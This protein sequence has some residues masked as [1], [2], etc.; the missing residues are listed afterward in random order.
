MTVERIPLA[1]TI[2]S[3]DGSLTKDS[4]TINCFFETRDGVKQVVKR[5]GLIA[6]AI[7]PS[8]P[9]GLARGLFA[10]SSALWA[11][12]GSNLYKIDSNFASTNYGSVDPGTPYLLSFTQCAPVVGNYTPSYSVAGTY[13]FTVPTGVTSMTFTVVGAGA[14]GGGSSGGHDAAGG[15]PSTNTA[16]G[17]GGGGAGDSV[18]STVAVTAGHVLS[19]VIG[20]G[21]TGG[22]GGY[23]SGSNG[24]N[25]GTTTVT[26]TT[27]ST[28]LFTCTGGIA[29]LGA[30]CQFSDT[31]HGLGGAGS[32]TGGSG[33]RG[34]IIDVNKFGLGG[35]SGVPNQLATKGGGTNGGSITNFV[36]GLNACGGGGGASTIGQGGIGGSGAGVAGT[37]GSGGSGAGAQSNANAGNTGGK[38]G[39]GVV[40]LTY[41]S[42]VIDGPIFLHNENTAWTIATGGGSTTVVTSSFPSGPFAFGTCY[43]DGYVFVM[44]QLGRIYNSNLEDPTTW[45]ALNYITAAFDPD[46]GVAIAKHLNYIVAFGAN[47]TQ[48][49]YDAAA[50][51]GGVGSPL[52]PNQSANSN[53]GCANGHTI[54]PFDNTIVWVGQSKTQGRS[55][56]LLDGLSPVKI[57]TRYI[58]RIIDNDLMTD[59]RATAFKANGH[60]FYILTLKNS[61]VTLVYDLEEKVWYQWN[62]LASG[63]FDVVFFASYNNI[64]YMIDDDNG[65]LYN[66]SDNIFT[67]NGNAYICSGV[68]A[69]TDSGSTKRKFYRRLEVIGDKTN[70]LLTVSHSGNDYGSFSTGRLI[71]LSV[72]RPQLSILG[73]DRRRAWAWS[74]SANSPLRLDSFEVTYDIGGEGESSRGQSDK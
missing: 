7:S 58:D 55:V 13:S 36:D 14:G 48:F 31:T 40:Q 46:G 1:E 42:S 65:T 15:S 50:Q 26:N 18:T 41:S 67:D 39:D 20:A 8:L 24:T 21:G 57:S 45:G 29:G 71:D 73:S 43:L 49:F 28:V 63:Y 27:T 35:G 6:Q 68:T 62:S 19:I 3:R 2:E 17:G 47:T 69:I 53:I 74:F 64:P 4:K 5:P 52:L 60:T 23:T 38:G 22:A 59:V 66:V 11:G 30:Y 61:G 10:S 56:Y 37:S 12:I 33:G 9:S 32:G 44:T 51:V 70:G 25:G 54:A 16:A 72:P 34:E